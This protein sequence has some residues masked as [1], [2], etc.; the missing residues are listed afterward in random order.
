MIFSNFNIS[1]DAIT[2]DVVLQ[3]VKITLAARMGIIHFIV[4][5]FGVMNPK[6]KQTSEIAEFWL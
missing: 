2:P 4:V 3:E 5:G 6:L 1:G